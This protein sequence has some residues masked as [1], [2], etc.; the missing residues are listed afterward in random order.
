MLLPLPVIPMRLRGTAVNYA[1]SISPVGGVVRVRPIH[2]RQR[3][4]GF[5]FNLIPVTTTRMADM[6]M[7]K[8]TDAAFVVRIGM[9]T[10]NAPQPM[11]VAVCA[12]YTNGG[13]SS[14]A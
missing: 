6:A 8:E 11:L 2:Q 9:V 10:H 13:P 12:S 4:R 14:E 7:V 5:F 1:W 3:L